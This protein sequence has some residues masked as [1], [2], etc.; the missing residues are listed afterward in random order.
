MTISLKKISF[1]TSN[2]KKATDFV[3]HGLGVMEFTQ[4]IP[5]VLDKDCSTVALYKAADT[6]LDYVVVEDTSLW[7]EG[8]DFLPTEIKQVWSQ[9]KDDAS[10]NNS[11]ALWSVALCLSTPQEYIISHAS[12]PGFLKYP[13]CPTGYHFDTLLCVYSQEQK[14][15]VHF[16]L[17]TSSEKL[18]IGPRFKALRQL[19]NAIENSDYS[20]VVRI[21]KSSVPEWTGAYQG[22]IGVKKLLKK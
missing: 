10:F 21:N 12:T 3:S 19:L 22:S 5:E 14:T 4:D 16:E 20:Q 8:A 1:L 6:K 17:L 7:V 9:I 15:D 11:K 18:S 13:A 2:T